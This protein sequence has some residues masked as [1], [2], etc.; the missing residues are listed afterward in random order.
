[1]L[2]VPAVPVGR[3]FSVMICD[4][5][6]CNVGYIGSRATGQAAGSWLVVGPGWQGPTPPGIKGV[7]RSTTWFALVAYRTR[8]FGPDDMPDAGIEAR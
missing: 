4:G 6:T 3:Y 7:I 8:L 5:N 1:M 2:S